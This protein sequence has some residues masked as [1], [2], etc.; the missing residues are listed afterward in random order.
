LKKLL[1]LKE[2]LTVPEASRHLSILFGEEVSE[3]DVLR[4]AL[5]GHLTLSVHFVN[6]ATAQ[7]GKTIP[8]ADAKIEEVPN[9]FGDGVIKMIKGLLLS[10]DR[11][12]SFAKQVVSIDGVWDLPMLGDEGLDVERKYQSLTNGPAV[13]LTN[14]ERPLVNRPDDTWTRIVEHFSDN[15]YFNKNNLKSPRNHPDNYYP[16]GALP[17]DAV[18]VVR[19]SALQDLEARLSEPGADVERPVGQRE[20]T[21]AAA[22]S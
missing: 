14:L 7:C 21:T 8:L 12:L 6:H 20:R 19:T 17:A 22:S 15:K 18:F 5:D 10:D 16:A 13:E 1:K 2:W 11:V 4:L 3:A 9:I